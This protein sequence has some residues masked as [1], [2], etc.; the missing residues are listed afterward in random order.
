[1][2]GISLTCLETITAQ[3]SVVTDTTAN[4]HS[5]LKDSIPL[6]GAKP[7]PSTVKLPH[8]ADSR[9]R[10]SAAG[11][12]I[13]SAM[14][15]YG[16][17]ALNNPSLRDLNRSTKSELSEDHPRFNTGI[18]NVLQY[19]PTAAVYVLNLAGIHGKHN[20]RDR[21]IIL[22]ISA[23][24]TAGTTR[25]LKTS[26]H[27]E[28]PDGSNNLSFPSGHTSNAFMGAE[29][30]YQEYKDVSP[31][32]GVAG[33]AVATATG[34]LRMLNNRHWLSDVVAGAGIG[35]LG[36][37]AAYWMY[38]FVQRKL[39]PGKKDMVVLPYYNAEWKSMGLSLSLT[40]F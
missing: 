23:V 16:F 5:V 27:E 10:C 37:K 35:I 20:L 21:T 12:I 24:I 11:L 29:F 18:D 17:I 6:T 25:I 19:T 38:P 33:Y 36:T 26:T 2:V 4:N 40:K 31:W 13:P 15:T 9:F 30:L 3:Q 32:I 22:G 28:R 14:V 8:G 34:A 7:E 39:F 1:M